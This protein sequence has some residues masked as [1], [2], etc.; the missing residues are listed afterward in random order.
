[1]AEIYRIKKQFDLKETLDCGQAFRWEELEE[2][3]WYGIAFDK[4][5]IIEQTE[6]EHIFHCSEKEFK[7]IWE[8]YFDLNENYDEIR[9]RLGNLSPF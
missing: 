6:T 9:E 1:M 5:L 3:K 4:E 7:E 8:D 2:N